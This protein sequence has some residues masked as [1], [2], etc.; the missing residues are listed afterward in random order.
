M[1][2][3]AQPNKNKR[4]KRRRKRRPDGPKPGKTSSATPVEQEVVAR[5]AACGRCSFFLSEYR[6]SYKPDAFATAV[7]NSEA[8]W[9]TLEWDDRLRRMVFGA[10]G[11]RVD[12]EWSSFDGCCPECQRRFFY[13]AATDDDT[14]VFRIAI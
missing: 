5:F 2:S 8:G 3:N 13:R 9:L 14:A 11:S 7:A 1:N 6:L 4:S 10:F 12:I